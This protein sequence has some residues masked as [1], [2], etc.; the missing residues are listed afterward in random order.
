MTPKP[1]APPAA[2]PRKIDLLPSYAPPEFAY[3]PF[4]DG[5]FFYHI[6]YY[7]S[8]HPMSYGGEKARH[9]L[10]PWIREIAGLK[11]PTR[12][13]SL[14]SIH[15]SPD[16]KVAAVPTASVTAPVHDDHIHV[17]RHR[18]AGGPIGVDVPFAELMKPRHV[19][20]E[21]QV[22]GKMYLFQWYRFAEASTADARGA[23][24]IS[25]R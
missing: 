2:S 11:G 8:L 22:N 20:C 19:D 9:L 1:Q 3:D 14:A 24:T 16:P 6:L 10:I 7:K 5:R 23:G 4:G 18:L 12:P 25:T 13:T 17:L 15:L 21:I